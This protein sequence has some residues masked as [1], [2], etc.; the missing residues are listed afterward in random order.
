MTGNSEAQGSI[1]AVHKLSH[2]KP[3]PWK[4]RKSET[5]SKVIIPPPLMDNSYV[6]E[7]FHFFKRSINYWEVLE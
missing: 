1:V 2:G 7:L 6:R 3:L 4:M 5:P